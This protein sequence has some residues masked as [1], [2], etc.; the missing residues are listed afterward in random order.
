MTKSNQILLNNTTLDFLE[1]E[2]FTTYNSI[3]EEQVEHEL[4]ISLKR[5]V[6]LFLGNYDQI[7]FNHEGSY[8]FTGVNMSRKLSKTEQTMLEN[9]A[10]KLNGA[11]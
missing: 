9:I 10:K 7:E 5:E 2:S 6:E 3:S 4:P 11:E 1:K 8:I